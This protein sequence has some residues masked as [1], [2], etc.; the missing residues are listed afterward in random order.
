MC[1]IFLEGEIMTTVNT[2]TKEIKNAVALANTYTTKDGDIGG[3]IVISGDAGFIKV[4]ATDMIETISI[5]EIAF[6]CADITKES[7]KTIALDG[8]KLSLVLKAAKTE[9]VSFEINKEYITVVSGGSRIKINLLAKVPKIKIENQKEASLLKM[10]DALV[11]KLKLIFH[12]VDIENPKPTL[13]GALLQIDKN[14]AT[15]V[16]T[17]TRRLAFASVE[18]NSDVSHDVLIPRKGIA[19]IMKLFDGYGLEASVDEHSIVVKAANLEYSVKLINGD[20]PQWQRI[21]PRDFA[22][23]VE[24]NSKHLSEIVQEASVF[25]NEICITLKDG[26]ICIKD[27]DGNTD[28]TGQYDDEYN[29]IHVD[30]EFSIDA[31]YILDTLGVCQEEEITLHFNETN[32]PIKLSSKNSYEEICMPIVTTVPQKQEVENAA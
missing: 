19:S 22:Q 21:V 8:K 29:S 6:T 16:A 26:K 27:L 12:T 2:T 10:T 23:T 24:V 4:M 11:S 15:V 13:N 30:M 32:L 17:D 31:R 14:K 28:V 18:T 25:S 1:A 7:F 20:F 3:Q 5:G 9:N